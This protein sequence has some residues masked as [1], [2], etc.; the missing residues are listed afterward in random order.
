MLILEQTAIGDIGQ[1]TGPPVRARDPRETSVVEGRVRLLAQGLP[2]PGQLVRVP[3]VVLV[4]EGQPG[5]PANSG[6][7]VAGRGDAQVRLTHQMDAGVAQ[8]PH[9]RHILGGSVIDH[10]NLEL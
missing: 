6:P 4:E 10:E 5:S 2:L 9:P 8:F 7:M 3:R 1:A